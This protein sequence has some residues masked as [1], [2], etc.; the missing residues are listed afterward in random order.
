MGTVKNYRRHDGEGP[1]SMVPQAPGETPQ[2]ISYRRNDDIRPLRAKYTGILFLWRL[3][4]VLFCSY[5]HPGSTT[6]G[7]DTRSP[8]KSAKVG[9]VGRKRPKQCLIRG[10][11]A[12][13]MQE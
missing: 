10:L 6:M 2:G 1:I 5:Y 9:G 11:R 4:M 8:P 7:Q 12:K 13:T 3:I